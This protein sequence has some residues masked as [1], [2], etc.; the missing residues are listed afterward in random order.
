[1]PDAHSDPV[2]CVRVTPDENYIVST[3]KDDTIKI[4]DLRKQ[5]LLQTF[6]HERFQL[7]SNNTRLCV[8]HNSQ[9]VVCGTKSGS[10]IFYDLKARELVNI[11]SDQHKSQVVAVEWQPKAERNQKIATIDDLGGLIIWSS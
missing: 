8:S 11:V 6:E 5:K 4:W 2:A 1:M 7:G 9:F 3:S 10:V